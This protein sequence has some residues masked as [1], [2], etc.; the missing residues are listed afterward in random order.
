MLIDTII[1]VT[2]S[3]INNSLKNDAQNGLFALKPTIYIVHKI[4]SNY[5]DRYWISGNREK[6]LIMGTSLNGLGNKFAS[7]DRINISDVREIVPE[8]IGDSIL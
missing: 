4:S 3:T 1:F 8:L 7:V 2:N 6:G 5:H